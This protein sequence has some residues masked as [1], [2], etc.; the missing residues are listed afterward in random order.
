M[1]AH[2]LSFLTDKGWRAETVPVIYLFIYLFIYIQKDDIYLFIYLFV[3]RRTIFIYL[4]IYL[5]IRIQKDGAPAG[6]VGLLNVEVK[7]IVIL[8]L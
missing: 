2:C 8:V 6:K 1:M 7:R 5:F 3:Y 4:F